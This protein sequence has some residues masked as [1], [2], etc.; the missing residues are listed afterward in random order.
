MSDSDSDETEDEVYE[1]IVID[2]GSYDVK[3]GY[4]GMDAP[5]SCTGIS[6]YFSNSWARHFEA[7]PFCSAMATNSERSHPISDGK[8]VDWDCLEELWAFVFEH[9]LQMDKEVVKNVLMIASLLNNTSSDK[10]HFCQILFEKFGFENVCLRYQEA[11]ALMGAGRTT[12]VVTNIGYE[13]SCNVPIIEGVPQVK[14]VQT[15]PIGGRHINEY[16]KNSLT[17]KKHGVEI[18]DDDVEH[19]K[20]LHC[21]TLPHGTYPGPGRWHDEYIAENVTEWN[22]KMYELG[23]G[24][25]PRIMGYIN[26]EV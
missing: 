15:V 11:M 22:K 14:A 8:I 7:I 12:G 13:S 2:N 25:E 6:S 26:S 23:G 20:K 3:S 24:G 16:I 9:E 19:I 10:E 5:Q 4:A 17:L 18:T 1:T 21:R